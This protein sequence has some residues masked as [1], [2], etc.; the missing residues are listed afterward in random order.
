MIFDFLRKLDNDIFLLQ[1]THN[2]TMDDENLWTKEW[3][4]QTFWSR[5]EKRSRGVAIM[6]N[7]N[8]KLDINIEDVQTDSEGRTVSIRTIIEDIEY[9]IASIYAPNTPKRRKKYFNE[10][11]TQ[12]TGTDN[13]L[14]GGD[15]N[16]IDRPELDKQ[17]GNPMSGTD[18][19]KELRDLTD[20]L[21]LEDI[22]RKKHQNDKEFTWNDKDYSQRSRLDRWYIPSE[23]S[24]KS[25]TNITACPYSDHSAVELKIIATR[26]RRRGRG[27]WKMNVSTL[28]DKNY[29]QMMRAFLIYWRLTKTKYNNSAEWWDAGKTKVKAL[30]IAHCVKKAKAQRTKEYK[31]SQKL[32][33]L[34]RH[35]KPDMEAITETERQITE[36]DTAKARGVQIRSRATWIEQGE[37]STKYFFSLEKKKQPNNTIRELETEKETVTNDMD[38]LTT[39]HRFYQE[40]YSEENTEI[41]LDQQ[42]W[43]IQQLDKTLDE[44]EQSL[45]EGPIATEELRTALQEAKRNKAPGPDGIPTEFYETFWAELK[46]NL[47]EVLNDNYEYGEMTESQKKAI[48]R[49]LYKKDNKK[50]LK[51]WRPISLLNTDYKLTAKV[52][53]KRLQKVLPII[54]DEDQTCGVPGRTIYENLF[55]IRD[56][57]HQSKIR[58]NNLILVNLDQEKA[59]DR[60]NRRF[61]QR[62][63]EKMNFGP[64]FR[65][66]VDV[67]YVGANCVVLNNGWTSDPIDL[68]RGVRQGC[69][70]SPLLYTIIAET[71]GNAIRKDSH[72]EGVKI[73]G[74]TIESKISQYADDATLT[75]TD[76]LSVTRSFDIISKFEA[77]TGGKLNMEKTEGIYIGCDAGRTHGPV[78]IK[79]KKDNIDVLGTKIGNNQNQ[80]W[81]T[82][83]EKTEKKLER[84]SPRKLSIEGRA[85]LIR[86]YALATIIYLTTVFSIPDP[87]ITRI[88]KAIFT[89][90][91]KNGTEL[92]ARATCFLPKD[93]GG[94]NIPNIQITKRTVKTKWVKQIVDQR[95]QTKWIHFARYWLGIPLSTMRREWI[96]LRSTLKPHAGP[97][98][99]PKHYQTVKETLQ[100]NK[101]EIDKMTLQQIKAKTLYRTII[102]R[103]EKPR[104]ER[105]WERIRKKKINFTQTWRE[106]W[107]SMATNEEKETMWKLTHRVL[108]TRSYLA[109][110]GLRITTKCPFCNGTEDINHAVIGCFRAQQLWKKVL[111][112][113]TAI[114]GP[115]ETVTIT[116][117]NIVFAE[118]LPKHEN[119][120]KLIRYLTMVTSD[121]IWRARNKK[122]FDEK[123][124]TQDIDKILTHRIK[125][126][127]TSDNINNKDLSLE[128]IWSI[129]GILCTYNEKKLVLKI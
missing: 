95:N 123:T 70:L 92:V 119:E 98:T 89:F 53:A 72:I 128:T 17:G 59:F 74:T 122:V 52:I 44:H 35:I 100:E 58:N 94:L 20:T 22:W 38:I 121:V 55:R 118:K 36:I 6:I 88:N 40:L 99:I 3:G 102:K 67:L 80:Q 75:V 63:L 7:P 101:E 42:E 117:N 120:R 105:K 77:A 126:R 23:L 125:Q 127:I 34:K 81:K 111:E 84:W 18:G 83:L 129:K 28:K 104:A 116:M 50:L 79:W 124:E 10:L 86:T 57:V 97:E 85:V 27:F 115:K 37:R 113:I 11:A 66:W 108:P 68:Q 43:L 65:K 69:P 48:I 78:P 76:D 45:C 39:T 82:K 13:L 25:Q 60:V 91:W 19:H 73:P 29:Q 14:L 51:N 62:T 54:I 2:A 90:L 93:Q 5:G 33:E 106:I 47:I 21:Q 56:I 46:D 64:S 112:W 71:L 87:I 12:L 1:E 26:P 109:K 16:C 96:W 24:D 9:N 15:F 114:S 107:N 30:T 8:T 4:G 49:L 32:T 103:S 61:L 41:D 31:L 110:W